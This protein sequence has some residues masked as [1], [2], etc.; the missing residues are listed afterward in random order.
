MAV[1]RLNKQSIER[2]EEASFEQ[3]GVLERGDL[4]R[5]L[6]SNITVIAP[7]VLIIAEEFCDW[8]ESRRR[9]DLL[10]V[11]RSANLVVIELKRDNEGGHMELQA[12]RYAAMVSNMTFQQAVD[13][14]QR[15]LDQGDE[16]CDASKQLLE[17]LGWGEPR[18]EDFA[19]ET[20][21]IL[22]AAD[23]WK[24]LTTTVLWLNDCGLDVRCVRMKPYKTDSEVFVDVQQIVPLPEAQEYQIR[25]REKSLTRREAIRQTEPSTGHWFMN[26]GEGSQQ[27]RSWEDCKRYGFMVA[28]GAGPYL[29]AIRRLR[30][31]D[32]VFAYLSRHGYVGLGE[33]TAEAVPLKQFVPIGH[34]APLFDLPLQAKVNPEDAGDWCVGV[35][36]LIALERGEGIL[37]TR[38]YRSTLCQI[39]QLELVDDLHRALG[40]ERT[41]ATAGGVDGGKSGPA[42]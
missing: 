22:V 38:A 33:V 28:A 4:Q 5:L 23:F 1:F 9:I 21:I 41:N 36:W 11:D 27:S 26:T 31:G 13:V 8:D 39:H 3:L 42:S 15:T 17:Y 25:V 7:D 32:K 12:V 29:N 19:R 40:L 24:E 34:T 20:R 6:K 16:K 35:R 2:I 10:G 18:E 30:V 14:F 37:R